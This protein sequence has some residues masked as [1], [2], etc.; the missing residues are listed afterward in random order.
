LGFVPLETELFGEVALGKALASFKEDF[1][2]DLPIFADFD[3][4][5][6]A[7][8][9]GIRHG[10]DRALVRLKDFYAHRGRARDECPSPA[11]RSEYADR[12]EG[13]YASV[14]RQDR[15]VGG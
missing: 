8:F 3:F 5:H 1:D 14:E 15:P 2:G 9:R 11:P 10:G 13:E 7:D 4:Y 12:G 6:L